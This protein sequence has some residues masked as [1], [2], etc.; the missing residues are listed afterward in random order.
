MNLRCK[1]RSENSNLIDLINKISPQ[2][3]FDLFFTHT[4]ILTHT[5][6]ELAMKGLDNKLH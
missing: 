6:S 2:F 3:L 5:F 1:G 4:D